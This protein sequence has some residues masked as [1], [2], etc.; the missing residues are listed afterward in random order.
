VAIAPIAPM[1][2]KKNKLKQSIVIGRKMKL[3][4]I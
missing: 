4:I 1:A 3:K 2:P